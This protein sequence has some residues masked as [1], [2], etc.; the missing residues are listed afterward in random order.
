MCWGLTTLQ[1]VDGNPGEQH[2]RCG[3][4]GLRQHFGVVGGWGENTVTGIYPKGSTAGLHQKGLGRDRCV[5]REQRPLRAF[6]EIWKWKF[7]LHVKD[8]RYAVRIAN[9]KT[10]SLVGQT[11]TQAVTTATWIN[12][13]MI[14]AMARI[15]SMGMGNA[16]FLASRTVKE[17]L[18]IGALD[19]SQNALEKLHGGGQPVRQRR[20]GQRGRHRHRHQRRPAGLFRRAGAYRGSDFGNRGPRGL[21]ENIMGMLDQETCAGHGSGGHF[22]RRHRRHQRLR[23]R[24]RGTADA[25]LV[26]EELWINALVDTTATSGGAATVQ[27]VLQDSADNVTFADV[28]S[29]PVVALRS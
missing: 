29:G 28:L 13:L 17:M 15:P 23:L 5:R 27:V 7:G 26:S 20:P 2:H 8:W 22:H 21:K 1:L 4:L 25:A 19:K 18:S 10:A 3:R 12:K 24:Q 9:V 11:G 16:T 14:K 6:A